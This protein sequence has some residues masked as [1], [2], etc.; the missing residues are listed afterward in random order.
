VRDFYDALARGDGEQAA[1]VVAPEMR[2]DGDLSAVELTHSSL[3]TP[4]RV[5]KVDPITDDRV[6]VRYHF[7]S[8][9]NHICL[10]SAIVDTTHPGGGALISSIHIFHGC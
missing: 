1:A 5:T 10:G 4:L 6:F 9:D 2:E 3:R 8:A 7:V